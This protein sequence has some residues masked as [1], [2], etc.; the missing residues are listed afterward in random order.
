MPPTARARRTRRP[1]PE[2]LVLTPRTLLLYLAARTASD[3]PDELA[4]QKAQL[5]GLFHHA[6]G[7][8]ASPSGE[9]LQ[10][11]TAPH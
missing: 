1:G 3:H 9:V 5:T 2:A 6:P 8:T 10:L 4:H 7:T 11:R